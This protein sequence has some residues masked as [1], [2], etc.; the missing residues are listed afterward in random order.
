MGTVLGSAPQLTEVPRAGSV[1][2]GLVSGLALGPRWVPGSVPG[3]QVPGPTLLDLVPEPVSVSESG[4]GVASTGPGVVGSGA[5]AGFGDGVGSAEA[6]V[7]WVVV[8][9]PVVTGG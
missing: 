1:Q 5:G 2:P 4:A 8:G 7:G 3:S 9:S 6:G